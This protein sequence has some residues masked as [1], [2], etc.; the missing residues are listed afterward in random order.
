MVINEVEKCQNPQINTCGD[1]RISQSLFYEKLAFDPDN[2]S[3][4]VIGSFTFVILCTLFTLMYT[5]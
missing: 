3:V 5:V 2:S 4:E 1:Y